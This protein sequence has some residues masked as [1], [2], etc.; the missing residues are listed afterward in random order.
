MSFDGFRM[1]HGHTLGGTVYEFPHLCPGSTCAIAAWLEKKR[2]REAYGY[3]RFTSPVVAQSNPSD[4][5]A[6]DL[7]LLRALAATEKQV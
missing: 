3:E 7:L 2:A 1:V 5:R 6:H 4:L